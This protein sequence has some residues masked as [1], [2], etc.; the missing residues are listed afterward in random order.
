MENDSQQSGLKLRQIIDNLM[1]EKDELSTRLIK[2]NNLKLLV[3]HNNSEVNSSDSTSEDLCQRSFYLWDSGILHSALP[4]DKVILT[5]S[6]Q[7]EKNKL[8]TTEYI[9]KLSGSQID[10]NS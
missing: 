7:P 10:A 2:V 8:F 5:N 6:S 9:I 4:I 3:N 1:K